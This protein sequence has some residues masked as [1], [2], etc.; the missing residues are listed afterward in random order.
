MNYSVI[1]E[2]FAERHFIKKFSKQ[3][4]MHWDITR[5]A[6]MFEFERV[7]TLLCTDKAEIISSVDSVRIVKTKFKV[8]GTNV[9][10]KSSGNRCIVAVH[11]RT[12]IVYVLLVYSKKDFSPK[13][14]TR[15]WREKIK[16]A[17]PRYA[18]LCT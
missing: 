6:L 5:K 7:D 4:G 18:H 9:S 13:H 11:E 8:A 2:V 14:E 15:Q 3:F 10:A 1:F 12:H 17:Y 16:Q